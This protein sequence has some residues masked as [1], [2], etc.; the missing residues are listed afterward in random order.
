MDLATCIVPPPL[1]NVMTYPNDAVLLTDTYIDI[2][3]TATISDAIDTEVDI[4]AVWTQNGGPSL[5]NTSDITISPITMV[6]SN[7]IMYR[8]RLR[9]NQLISNNNNDIFQCTVTIQP[10]T[11]Y[12]IGSSSDDSLALSVGGNYISILTNIFK[13]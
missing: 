10:L 2:D 12:I 8:S 4:V 9:I 7:N 11:P 5:D 3:C 13:I 6:S 1:V